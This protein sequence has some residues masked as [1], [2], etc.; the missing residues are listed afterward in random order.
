MKDDKNDLFDLT[1]EVAIVTGGSRGIGRAIAHALAMAGASVVVSSR[2][3]EA[4]DA[5]VDE[6]EKS[7]GI[8]HAV[9]CNVTYIDQLESLVEMAR[10]RFGSVTCLVGNAAVNPHYG[11][12]TEISQSAFEKIINCNIRANLWLARYVLPDMAERKHGSLIFVS[13]I[14][15][16]KGGDDIGMY[17]TS[18]A[19]LIAMTRNLAVGWGEHGITVNTI[20]PGLIRTDFA[21]ALWE[22][23]DRRA[24]IE[25]TYPLRRIGEPA[26]IAGTAVFLASSASRYMT[27]QVLVVDGGSTIVAGV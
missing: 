12:M 27:G 20:A 22:D 8:A 1:G 24:K 11:P 9:A 25:A 23:D 6:I 5:V 15:G 19:G 13:S 18:K 14:A 10:S 4:C 2:M 26:D 21:R 3:K 7:G 17:G 16:L